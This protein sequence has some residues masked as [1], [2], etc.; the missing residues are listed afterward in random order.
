MRARAVAIRRT[1]AGRYAA[2][3]PQ[4]RQDGGFEIELAGAVDLQASDYVL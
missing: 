1:G 4:P 3:R 2:D